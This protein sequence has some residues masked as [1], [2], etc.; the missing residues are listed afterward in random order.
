LAS[1]SLPPAIEPLARFVGGLAARVRV[2]R[3]VRAESGWLGQGGRP[4]AV[5]SAPALEGL[6]R[7]TGTTR[8]AQ[9]R[10]RERERQ[11]PPARR[12]ALVLQNLEQLRGEPSAVGS[13]RQ[14][15]VLTHCWCLHHDQLRPRT[16]RF[17]QATVCRP[18]RRLHIGKVSE[19]KQMHKPYGQ[20]CTREPRYSRCFDQNAR[21]L[22][23]NVRGQRA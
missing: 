19:M 23:Q 6:A 12:H 2:V 15:A 16:K 11:R 3:L 20:Q 9:D 22:S 5:S 8:H 21:R 14:H 1:R 4:G 17:L 18:N 10:E 7:G 13:R